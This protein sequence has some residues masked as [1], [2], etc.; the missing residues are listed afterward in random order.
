M[1]DPRRPA[2][3]PPTTTKSLDISDEGDDDSE[4]LSLNTRREEEEP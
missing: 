3:P 4:P 1:M 2:G